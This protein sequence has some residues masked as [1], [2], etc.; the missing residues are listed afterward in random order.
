MQS[1]Q[2]RAG[3]GSAGGSSPAVQA[4]PVL[5][6]LI[7]GGQ[8][9]RFGGVRSPAPKLQH[10]WNGWYHC[11]GHTYGTWLPG[12]PRGF[13][14]RHHRRHVDGDY[15]SPPPKGKYEGLH[16]YSK[17]LMGRPAVCLGADHRPLIAGLLV[18][19][20]M[21]R[22]INVVIACVGSVHFH[23]LARISDCWA[24]HWIGIAKK[25]SSHFAKEAGGGAIGGVWAAGGKCQPIA[26]RQH[27]LATARYI[28]DHR[29]EGAAVW[30][31][32]RIFAPIT[33]PSGSLP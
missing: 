27:Q 31:R 1:I 33:A 28:W 5:G 18:E 25:E 9:G 30:F 4:P 10:P 20:L 23:I 6:G 21:R 14:T 24:D 3:G 12:D 17:S 32:G 11:M 7:L 16:R 22:K 29:M 8:L 2:Q 26:N 19:S 15:K 13:R